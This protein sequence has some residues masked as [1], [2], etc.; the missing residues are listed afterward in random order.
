M[1]NT[2]LLNAIIA[3][4]Q[5]REQAAS[6]SIEDH[7]VLDVLRGLFPSAQLF[8]NR[9]ADYLLIEGVYDILL[10]IKTGGRIQYALL[11]GMLDDYPS[12]DM[13]LIQSEQTEPGYVR[14]MFNAPVDFNALEDFLS[15][16]IA[17][18]VKKAQHMSEA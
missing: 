1:E 4:K 11:P 7:E 2:T 17:E 14:A 16:K 15:K 5:A 6:L 8:A 12:I 13:R 18:D 9:D 10:R 3:E